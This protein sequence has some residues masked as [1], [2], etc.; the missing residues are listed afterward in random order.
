MR[1]T[2]TSCASRPTAPSGSMGESPTEAGHGGRS[3]VIIRQPE[4]S[5][6][7]PL[8]VH[9]FTWTERQ[10]RIGY[11]EDVARHDGVPLS[12]AFGRR[13]RRYGWSIA[14]LRLL[15]G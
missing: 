1:G 5:L 3:L 7:Q 15:G 14:H 8:L 10:V 9:G 13:S 12:C 4:G 11:S 2:P 6:G